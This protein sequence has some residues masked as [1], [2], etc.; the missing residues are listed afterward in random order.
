MGP[1]HAV[2]RRGERPG[3]RKEKEGLKTRFRDVGD[4]ASAGENDS[5]I[6]VSEQNDEHQQKDTGE[7][8]KV[9]FSP[10]QILARL[11]LLDEASALSHKELG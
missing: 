4:G 5:G 11:P 9:T 6:F 2:G 8:D 7:K 10:D 3:A 1:S